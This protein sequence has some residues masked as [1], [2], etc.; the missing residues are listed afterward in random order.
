MLRHLCT[1][2]F[3]L[4]YYIDTRGIYL[5]LLS[6]SSHAFLHIIYN[7]LLGHLSQ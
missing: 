1:A 5:T 7:G 4:V 3:N 2:I 6:Q